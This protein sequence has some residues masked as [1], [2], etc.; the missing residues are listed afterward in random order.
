MKIRTMIIAGALASIATLSVTAVA[1]QDGAGGAPQM[2]PEQLKEMQAM[3]KAGMVTDKQMSKA[4]KDGTWDADL[5]FWMV[6]GAPSTKSTGTEVRTLVLDGRFMHSVFESN[7][8]GMPFK[9]EMML[10]YDNA[11]GVWQSNW[12]ENMS[13]SMTRETGTE[14]KADRIDWVFEETNPVTKTTQ[15]TWGNMFDDDADHLQ[16]A[17]VMKRLHMWSTE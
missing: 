10:G 2:S 15:T 17:E 11:R 14:V 6:P 7:F 1:I 4:L 8:M 5:E 16:P 9:G 13:T 12:C 3:Q